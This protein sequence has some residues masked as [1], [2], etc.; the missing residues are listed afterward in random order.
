MNV[1]EEEHV[2]TYRGLRKD[3]GSKTYLHGPMDHATTLKLPFR[4]GDLDLPERRKRYASNREEEEY[5]QM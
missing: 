4:V 2:L 1:K 5:S 3:T